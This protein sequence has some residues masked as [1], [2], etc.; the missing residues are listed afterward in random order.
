[1]CIKSSVAE[2]IVDV[3]RY[4]ANIVLCKDISVSAFTCH[5]GDSKV[6]LVKTIYHIAKNKKEI[7]IYVIID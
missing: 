2:E 7:R 5:I 4:T 1:M 3:P 6:S